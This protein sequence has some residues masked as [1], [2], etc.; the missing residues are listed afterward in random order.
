MLR[1]KDYSKKGIDASW[2]NRYTGVTEVQ[3]I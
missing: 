1:S 2:K 3:E